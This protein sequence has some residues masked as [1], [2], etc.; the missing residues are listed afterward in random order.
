[1]HKKDLAMRPI[2]SAT[3]TY[4]Y[5]LAKWLDNKLKALST[6]SNT[7]TDIFKFVND[8]QDVSVK[9]GSVLVSYDVCS[10][11]TNVPLRQ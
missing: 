5:P 9:D 2:L 11:F 10:L 4:N 7:I 8:L 6:N 1:M 3:G